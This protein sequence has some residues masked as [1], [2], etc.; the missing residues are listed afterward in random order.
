M[1]DF[2][3]DKI[4]QILDDIQRRKEEKAVGRKFRGFLRAIVLA[5]VM[6][7]LGYLIGANRELIENLITD[8]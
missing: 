6:F 3:K 7:C 8:D 2:I 5:V 1:L 4:A